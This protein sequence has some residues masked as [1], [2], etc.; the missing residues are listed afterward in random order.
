MF[1]INDE[2]V[3][4]ATAAKSDNL[5][6]KQIAEQIEKLSVTLARK[7]MRIKWRDGVMTLNRKSRLKEGKK[8]VFTPFT[9]QVNNEQGTNRVTYCDQAQVGQFGAIKYFPKGEAFKGTLV[10]GL[11]KV[12]LAVYYKLF[13]PYVKSRLLV[14]EDREAEAR[15]R[16][17]ARAKVSSYYFYLYNE[18]SPLSNDADKLVLIAKAFGIQGAD[19]MEPETLKDEIFKA[20]ELRES[21][22]K[23]GIS[24]LQRFIDGDDKIMKPLAD[25]QTLFDDGQIT[26]DRNEHS[27]KLKDGSRFFQLSPTEAFDLAVSKKK[28][29]M[30][31][32]SDEAAYSVINAMIEGMTPL[33]DVQVDANTDLESLTY[34]ELRAAAKLHGIKTYKRTTPQL[35]SELRDVLGKK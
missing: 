34:N 7:P 27:W 4:L 15:E 24:T 21:L 3:N 13:C 35:I 5:I 10:L 30:Y 8:M 12:E 16:A 26:L 28:L 2:K 33:P 9:V 6:A 25:I 1:Y 14:I 31:L 23:D 32:L 19:S 29:A 11:D 22:N 20:V 18:A 17:E